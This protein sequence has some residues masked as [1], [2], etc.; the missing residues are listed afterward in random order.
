MSHG[1]GGRESLSA[2]ETLISLPSDTEIVAVRRYRAP[3]DRV[4]AAFVTPRL[5]ERWW[6]PTGW[7][8]FVD[9]MEAR[10]GGRFRIRLLGPSGEVHL[11]VGTILELVPG[12]RLVRTLE[13]DRFPGLRLVETALFEDAD[14]GTRVTL[15]TEFPP[16]PDPERMTAASIQNGVRSTLDRLDQFLSKSTT[17][18]R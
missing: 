14:D 3:R 11:W 15:R 12:V 4:F 1:S 16:P 10:A 9:S 6:G 7:R 2:D 8:T 5:I 13:F 18:G 17:D